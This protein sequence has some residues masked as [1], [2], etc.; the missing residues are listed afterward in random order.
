M[1]NIVLFPFDLFGSPGSGAG[2]ELLADA[3]REAVDDT[4]AETRPTR[5][6]AFASR[7]RFQ[8]HAFETAEALAG[9]RDAGRGAARAALDSRRWTLWLG[10]NHLSVLPVYEELDPAD[11]VVQFDAHL[12]CY[13]LHDTRANLGHGNFLCHAGRLPGVVNVGHRD[14]FLSAADTAPYFRALHPAEAVERDPAGVAADLRR[15]AADAPRVWIDVDVDVFDPADCPAVA[16]PVP[17]GPR[18]AAVLALIDAAWGPNLAGVSL[19]EFVPGR[20]RDD[21]SLQLLGWL[22]EWLLLK[23]HEGHGAAKK[24]G[25]KPRG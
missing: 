16:E 22:Q 6:D 17:F 14:L 12:D 13:R 2:A 8:E 20:D 4:L 19:S 9:W 5:P 23:W 10:G 15:R 18:A 25:K 7:L 3:L 24:G 11:L 1:T 21:R